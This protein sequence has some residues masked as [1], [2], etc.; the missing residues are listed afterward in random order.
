MGFETDSTMGTTK[1]PVGVPD[2]QT[3]LL[4]RLD[5]HVAA[6]RDVFTRLQEPERIVVDEWT[7][8]DVLRHLTFWHESFARNT[9]ALAKGATPDPLSGTY[10]Q[11]NRRC[12]DEMCGLSTETL[13]D[14]LST[15]QAVVERDI[16]SPS[17]ALIPYRKGSKPYTPEEHLNL[18]S[19]HI[20]E[21]LHDIERAVAAA[22]DIQERHTVRPSHD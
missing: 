9:S 10:A 11:L 20:S 21:H 7:A 15:A 5:E 3:K 2:T 14:R 22:A 6:V 12:F 18:V 16:L 13:L 8:G 4:H 1:D 17:I 19:E